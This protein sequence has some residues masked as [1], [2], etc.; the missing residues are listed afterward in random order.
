MASPQREGPVKWAPNT[1]EQSFVVYGTDD[2]RGRELFKLAETVSHFNCYLVSA[3]GEG[4]SCFRPSSFGEDGVHRLQRLGSVLLDQFGRDADRRERVPGVPRVGLRNA[5]GA[6]AQVGEAVLDA[7]AVDKSAARGGLGGAVQSG[8]ALWGDGRFVASKKELRKFLRQTRVHT[9]CHVLPPRFYRELVSRWTA[10]GHYLR[11]FFCRRRVPIGQIGDEEQDKLL[12]DQVKEQ[13]IDLTDQLKAEEAKGDDI[14]QL[15]ILRERVRKWTVVRGHFENDRAESRSIGAN[16]S[17]WCADCERQWSQYGFQSRQAVRDTMSLSITELS[18]SVCVAQPGFFLVSGNKGASNQIAPATPIPVTFLSAAG[19]DFCT[20]DVTL[21]EAP[22]YFRRD[23][24]VDEAHK[25]WCAWKD[26]TASGRLKE[27]LTALFRCIYSAARAQGITHMCMLPLGQGVF[28]RNLA[29]SLV[30]DVVTTYITVQLELLASCDWGFDVYWLNPANRA[31][32]TQALISK[33]DPPPQCTFVLHNRDV[34]FLCRE[35]A[36]AGLS[37]GFMNP[38]DCVGVMMSQFGYFWEEGRGPCYVGE[39]DWAATS[40]GVLSVLLGPNLGHCVVSYDPDAPGASPR[41]GTRT[42]VLLPPEGVPL[43]IEVH[44]TQPVIENVRPES[45]AAQAGVP[46]GTVTKVGRVYVHDAAGVERELR[47]LRLTHRVGDRIDIWIRPATGAGSPSPRRRG[48]E[49]NGA[50]SGRLDTWLKDRFGEVVASR[51][52][53][54]TLSELVSTKPEGLRAC[55]LTDGQIVAVQSAARRR[56]AA[57]GS[58]S[59]SPS[60]ALKK[61]NESKPLRRGLIQPGFGVGKPRFPPKEFYKIGPSPAAYSP[62][63]NRKGERTF[64][65]NTGGWSKTRRFPSEEGV[66]PHLTYG[67]KPGL[68]EAAVFRTHDPPPPV[69]EASTATAMPPPPA[70]S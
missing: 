4:A 6:E 56:R 58:R 37:T 35:L 12:E 49:A 20:P 22:K 29:D 66:V 8:K 44:P 52:A 3:G 16:F 36:N 40:T 70:A 60:E 5:G 68:A 53:G 42:R 46:P 30:Q 61:I 57:S 43:G 28:L 2:E 17:S 25:G 34:K 15:G 31:K 14:Q 38:S 23:P 48:P 11:F 13:L 19:I 67:T 26:E 39:E 62:A 54:K 50:G 45:P 69:Y 21:K 65:R 1:I 59:K 24:K 41:R 63:T 51:L 47:R 55:G 64:N 27:R 33:A 18:S 9:D 32:E 7:A 10:Q